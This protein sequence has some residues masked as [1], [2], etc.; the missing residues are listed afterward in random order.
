M[1][2]KTKLAGQPKRPMTAYFMWM[3]EEGRAMVKGKNPGASITEVAK[4]C[5]E[6]WREMDGNCCVLSMSSSPVLC[7]VEGLHPI[8]ISGFSLALY[9]LFASPI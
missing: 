5:G 6:E 9:V 4:K 3:N 8:P 7:T 2:K 1:V